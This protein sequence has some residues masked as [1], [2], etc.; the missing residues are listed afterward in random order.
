MEL[1]DTL[2][3]PVTDFPMRG[4]LPQREPQFLEKWKQED[5]YSAIQQSRQGKSLFVLHDGPPYANGHL[6][7]GHALNKIL[8]DIIIKQKSMQGFQA[9]YVP[10]WDCHG[11]PIELGVDKA[12]GKDK[13][14]TTAVD[15]RQLCREHAARY[16]E[17]QREEFQRFG[18]FG[19]WDEPYLTMDFAYEADIVRELGS[20][21]AKGSLYRGLK[22]I[23]WCCDCVT[24]LAEAEVEYHDHTSDSVY[25]AFPVVSALGGIIPELQGKTDVSIVIWTTTPW[26]LPANL[27]VCLNPELEYS[28]VETSRGILI[29]ASQL[30]G[31]LMQIF[32]FDEFS[33]LATF[34][35]AVLENSV[36]GHPFIERDSMV[37]MGDHVT[38]EAGTGAVH[39]A[40]GH[41]MEDYIVGL[42]YG[43][44]PYNPVD[45]HGVFRAEVPHFGGMH[46]NKANPAI[47]EHMK[48]SGS[49]LAGSRI[50]HSYPHCWRCKKPVIYR[51]TPQ[52]FIS[53]EHNDLREKS[54]QQI[55]EEVTW[56]P[57]WGRDRIYNM[58]ENRPD[59]CVSRQRLWGVPITV[60]YCSQCEEP[61]QDIAVFEK[62]AN[63]I[64]S[65]GVDA[66][67]ERP[68]SDFLQPGTTCTHCGHGEFYK[69]KDIL[70]VWFDS[71]VT[72]AAVLRKRG[73]PWPADMYLEGSDQHRGWFHSSLLTAVATRGQAPYKTVLTHGF[74]LDGKGRKMSK[75]M[76]NVVAPDAIIKKYG[77]DILRLWVAAE[78]YRDDLRISDEIINRLAESYRRIRNTARYMLGNLYDFNPLTDAILYGDMLEFDRYALARYHAF[79]KRVLDAYENYEF[80][81]I[82]HACNNF[83]SV[84]MSAQYL[85]IIKDRLYAEDADGFKRR[86]AQ[87]A[88]HLILSGMM[89]LLAPVL[90][91]TMEEVYQHLNEPEKL[92]SV[93]L[94]DF[95]EPRGEFFNE[96]L[97]ARWDRLMKLR[98]DVSKALELARNEKVIGHSLDARVRVYSNDRETVAFLESFTNAE[99][100]DSCIVS[101]LSVEPLSGLEELE[102]GLLVEVSKALGA[103]C[104]R[105]WISD[106][107]TGK[108]ETG[109]CPRCA[110]VIRDR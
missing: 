29:V 51:A 100:R 71:G 48:Q 27:A 72:H 16:I 78:D 50:E 20:F 8:K 104:E 99:L 83:C 74:V 25:V 91:F 65:E 66:W 54:L 9:P 10:G 85:D 18:V 64:E 84:D 86:S 28:A 59:W 68:I 23:Y 30:L 45:N 61:L 42:K 102:N 38:T 77:A 70:D 98:S 5:I 44:E 63:L 60:L 36:C 73:L 13:H 110:A 88:L 106:V 87:S 103:K 3:L 96:A 11:L 12:L 58:I 81:V 82:Y 62:A 56:V 4:N 7:I 90:S 97:M 75:S 109:L 17:I 101:Q 95:P 1:K 14:T 43:L 31:S 33:I 22:P 94:L 34:P 80:H 46:I 19:A 52:W 15:K 47:I 108:Q 79:E 39:T 105:C 49:L 40:P 21:M 53:M 55:K 41:G 93:H 107:D 24:A 76:G 37:I 57:A 6:H 32:G 67:Y 26:T 92:A 2:N 89:R 35:G 69:E